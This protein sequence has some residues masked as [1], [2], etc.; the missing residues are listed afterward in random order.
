[1]KKHLVWLMALP[2]VGACD[3]DLNG[4][5]G[6]TYD[7]ELSDAIS[8]IGMTT[9]RVLADDGDIEIV[10]RPDISTVRVYATACA[11]DRSTLGDI[12][13]DLFRNGATIEL[14]T[15]VPARDNA[16]LDLVIEVPE[17]LAVALYSEDGDIDVRDVDFVYIDDESGHISVRNVFFDVEIVD[18]SGDIDILNV[19]GS[20]DI[21]DGSGDIEVDDVGGDFL[22]RF[23]SS[24]SI[25]YRN[26]R[27]IVDIP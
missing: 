5:G 9:L 3:V 23:D 25:R 22:V 6:C 10:G 21:D 7:E 14:E 12:E 27:G 20:V 17:E 19:D 26:V 15:L 11:N 16:H 8:A 4:L 1:M 2:L 13:F 18:E 24:G